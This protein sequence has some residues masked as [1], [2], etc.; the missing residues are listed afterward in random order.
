MFPLA[1]FLLSKKAPLA[2]P[3]VPRFL[4]TVSILPP[5]S[6]AGQV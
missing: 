6:T 1:V 5:L 3:Q 4:F 2:M